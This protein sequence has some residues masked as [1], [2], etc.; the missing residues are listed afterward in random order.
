MPPEPFA[1]LSQYDVNRIQ[2]GPEDIRERNPHR[3]EFELLHGILFFEAGNELTVGV[4]HAHADAFWVRGHIPGRPLFPGVLMV[5]TAAQLCSF[6]WR[7]TYPEIDKF[8]GF[9]GIENTRFRGSVEPGDD[10]IVV[11]RSVEVKPRRAIFD[12][13]GFVNGGMVFETRI[14]GMPF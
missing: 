9:A 14:K 8:F 6:Y 10:L 12:A 5:E 1:D 2:Y 7:N 13:Q 11:G 4:H 3:Y